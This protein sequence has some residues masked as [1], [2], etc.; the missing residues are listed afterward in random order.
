MIFLDFIIP[1]LFF[2]YS[3]VIIGFIAIVIIETLIFAF[4]AKQKLKDSLIII[5]IA[6]SYSTICGY[7]VIG[8]TRLIVFGLILLMFG[9]QLKNTR[10]INF[11]ETNP[12]IVGL[13]GNMGM[14]YYKYHTGL[15]IEIL[16]N[17]LTQF[18]LALIVSIYIEKKVIK[19]KMS[20][21]RIGKAVIWA[22]VGSYIFL[23]G[24]MIFVYLKLQ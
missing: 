1:F 10:I 14:D 21:F 17:F 20:D 16:V 8:L 24:L 22:N 2:E 9:E 7:I 5:T 19:K 18:I 11:L 13:T 3:L 12:I 23:F 4:I 6:N 15:P